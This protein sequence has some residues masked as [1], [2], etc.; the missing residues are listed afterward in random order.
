MT[1]SLFSVPTPSRLLLVL[2]LLLLWSPSSLAQPLLSQG[3]SIVYL[4]LSTD[5]SGLDWT[6]S[7]DSTLGCAT[8]E[9]AC[10]LR[11]GSVPTISGVSATSAGCTLALVTASTTGRIY[12]NSSDASFPSPATQRL[13]I[14]VNSSQALALSITTGVPVYVSPWSDSPSANYMPFLTSSSSFNFL[15]SSLPALRGRTLVNLLRSSM[16]DF[17]LVLSVAPSDTKVTGTSADLSVLIDTCSY[18]ASTATAAFLIS[19]NLPDSPAP[20]NPDISVTFVNSFFSATYRP[21]SVLVYTST[22]TYGTVATLTFHNTV[23]PIGSQGVA[24]MMNAIP[25]SNSS[26]LPTFVLNMINSSLELTTNVLFASQSGAT[27]PGVTSW[28]TAPCNFTASSTNFNWLAPPSYNNSAVSTLPNWNFKAIS[29]LIKGMP[30]LYPKTVTLWNST[31]NDC[32]FY[33]AQQLS[34]LSYA[35]ASN[36]TPSPPN[37]T[38]TSTSLARTKPVENSYIVWTSGPPV[39]TLFKLNRFANVSFYIDDHAR[40]DFKDKSDGSTLAFSGLTSITSSS[41]SRNTNCAVVISSDLILDAAT[42]ATQCTLEILADIISI[43]GETQTQSHILALPAPAGDGAILL[44]PAI[45]I[46]QETVNTTVDL[47]NFAV[48][49]FA[50][51]A[52]I[53]DTV[54]NG[55]F[56]GLP[57]TGVSVMKI[58]PAEATCQAFQTTVALFGDSPLSRQSITF[59]PYSLSTVP[60]EMMVYYTPILTVEESSQGRLVN[61]S[62]A[63]LP[64]APVADPT[65]PV[66]TEVPS[67]T[68]LPPPSGFVCVGDVWVANGS[69]SIPGT[70]TVPPATTVEVQGNLTIGGSVIFGGS[71]GSITVT[72]CLTL[73]QLSELIIDLRKT[74]PNL[75]TKETPTL[76]IQQ[77]GANC[78]TDLSLLPYSVKQPDNSCEKIKSKVS[79]SSSKDSLV[80]LFV[81]DRSPCNKKWIILGSVLGALVILGVIGTIIA[82]TIIQRQRH[83]RATDQVK[84][85]QM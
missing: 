54:D 13:V 42:I 61:V 70:F 33:S 49:E 17:N 8:Q 5:T 51:S 4:T 28:T 67:S 58:C 1:I 79:P 62:F 57:I 43:P 38:S 9:T 25:L 7:C 2:A 20:S 29:S 53:M 10:V 59:T 21:D 81:T 40:L 26:L 6:G 24:I 37:P 55:S 56:Y 16:D 15:Q 74:N 72:G 60:K 36:P 69:V 11:M 46:L 3:T 63:V 30:I 35:S 50:P 34:I 44:T 85:A 23:T 64:P 41:G 65:T 18:R 82:Y 73:A 71:S 80:L 32:G 12:V 77:L 45:L 19:N 47:T 78:S 66:T 84:K 31:L 68:C 22:N 52:D 48:V 76:L 39:I 14:L 75:Y 83:Q 27:T